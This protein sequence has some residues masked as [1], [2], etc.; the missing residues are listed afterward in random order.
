MLWV[1]K[2]PLYHVHVHLLAPVLSPHPLPSSALAL[3]RLQLPQ[4]QSGI[5]K[6]WLGRRV[7][8]SL[9]FWSETFQGVIAAFKQLPVAPAEHWD[10]NESCPSSAINLLCYPAQATQPPFSVNGGRGAAFR[11]WLFCEWSPNC[12]FLKYNFSSLFL[13]YVC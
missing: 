9:A 3:V 10:G 13:H 4:G 12:K 2:H 6:P 5:P 7:V 8:S 11:I 1:Q